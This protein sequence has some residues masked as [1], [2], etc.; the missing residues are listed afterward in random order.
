MTDRFETLQMI[1]DNTLAA[2]TS[3]PSIRNEWYSRVQQMFF[4]AYN[5]GDMPLA[6]FLQPIGR[7]LKGEKPES[8]A[9]RLEGAYVECWNMIVQGLAQWEIALMIKQADSLARSIEGNRSENV[10]RAIASYQQVLITCTRGT[11]P[12]IWALI[13]YN[14]ADAYRSRIQ[15]QYTENLE[16]AIAHYEQAMQVYTHQAFPEQWADVQNNLGIAFSERM[17]GEEADNIEQ[18]IVHYQQALRVFTREAFPEQWAYVQNNLAIA[19]SRRIRGKRSDNIER[20]IA[21]CQQ[22]MEVYTRRAY[23]VEWAHVQNNRALAY[24]DR[25]EREYSDD[26][27]EQAI[28]HYQQALEVLTRDHFPWRWVQLQNN[29]AC[30]YLDRTLGV[31]ADN[32][33]QSIFHCQQALEVGTRATSPAKW[34]TAQGNLARAYCVRIHGEL[35]DNIKLAVTC[36]QNALEV[37]TRESRPSSYL[38]FQRELGDLYFGQSQWGEALK[39]YTAAIEVGDELCKAAYTEIG[40]EAGISKIAQLYANAAY[41]ELQN[42]RPDE[43]LLLLEHGKTRLLTEALAL[44]DVDLNTLPRQQQEALRRK[45]KTVHEL[46]AEM[47]LPPETPSRRSDNDLA[48]LLR[49]ARTD[50]NDLIVCIRKDHP[51]F[52]PTGLELRELLALVPADGALVA[53]LVTSQGSAVFVVPHGIKTVT[54]EN[55]VHLNKDKEGDDLY[56][57]LCDTQKV[58][59]SQMDQGKIARQLWTTLLESVHKNLEQLNVRRVIMMPSGGLQLL[60]LHAAW[61]EV[62]GQ[63]RAF[64][65]EYEIV[66]APSGYVLGKCQQRSKERRGKTA[67]VVGIDNYANSKWPPLE[68]ARMEAI[69]VA[70][71]LGVKP[72]LDQEATVEAARKVAPNSTYL[73]FSCHGAYAWG[74]NPFDSVLVLAGD[75]R[76]SLFRNIGSKLGLK[77]AQSVGN[78]SLKLS[79]IISGKLDVKASR[80]VTLS[81]CETGVSDVRQT[82][83]EYVGMPAGFILAGAAGV[84]SSLW[85][86]N[87]LSTALLMIRFYE[88]HLKDGLHPAAALRKAQLWLRDVT[89]SELAEFFAQ[90]KRQMTD[91][92]TI[93]I[94]PE[95]AQEKFRE[96]ALRDPDVRPYKHPYYWAAFAF[97]GA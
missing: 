44:G 19:Y 53:P 54:C 74:G 11:F 50:L 8:I 47:R 59:G 75:S 49:R 88:Y 31:K 34:A 69:S 67:L 37:A 90:Y 1:V 62:D 35:G 80:L 14:L 9:P 45:R 76:S 32:I 70:A 25:F 46:E 51:D 23:P 61:R 39:A 84:I 56:T 42:D 36:F 7:L 29:L 71:M 60:P 12:K 13:H 73:H 2:L 15:G 64:L 78:V 22:A 30:A 72:L 17:R 55:V 94:M 6:A 92:H 85:S 57:L 27:I 96:Y 38:E 83:D 89:N 26:S 33:E 79:E 87:D 77:T 24:N 86:V 40:R 20:S 5:Y 66:Y 81:A 95:L 21:H 48:S 28:F 10:E 3:P 18:A 68:N 82:P 97:Y 43:A 4:Q 16:Q 93:G 65:D 41:C 52:M 63:K 91:R 58:P